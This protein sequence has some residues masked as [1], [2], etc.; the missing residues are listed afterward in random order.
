[1]RISKAMPPR[2]DISR[3][4]LVDVEN[5]RADHHALRGIE[6]PLHIFQEVSAHAAGNPHGAV[7]EFLEFRDDLARQGR[8]AES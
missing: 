6:Q 1:M 4:V 2:A 3:L 5:A 7:S 8:V